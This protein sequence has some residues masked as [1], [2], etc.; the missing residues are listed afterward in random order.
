MII[1]IVNGLFLF[2]I[3]HCSPPLNYQYMFSRRTDTTG[4]KA[5]TNQVKPFFMGNP[6]TSTPFFGPVIQKKP[7]ATQAADVTADDLLK[8]AQG[9][10]KDVD[11][12]QNQIHQGT[13]ELLSTAMGG[14]TSTNDSINKDTPELL[15][16]FASFAANC[17]SL[18]RYIT[19]KPSKI[20]DKHYK[21]YAH[22][23]GNDDT[24][25]KSSGRFYNDDFHQAASDYLH[26]RD[27]EAIR[28]VGGF[29]KRQNDTINLPSDSSFGNALHE[30]VHR[31]SGPLF[32]T[33]FGQ[34]LNEGLTQRFTNKL[35]HEAHF[36]RETKSDYGDNLADMQLLLAKLQ[37]KEDLLARVYFMNDADAVKQIY[38]ALHL[39]PAG[40]N[41]PH[42]EDPD[43]ILKAIRIP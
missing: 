42:P 15:D 18:S 34:Y 33:Y 30:S 29:Y 24:S 12:M 39:L 20:K 3:S 6:V 37:G 31:L 1:F 7:A 2:V 36:T 41:L 26:T 19:L 9:T 10:V 23:R 32:Q 4:E 8:E 17:S 35:L 28:K 40:S 5:N 16:I 22:Y 25:S 21:T 27:R 11:D 43:N 14:I 13:C 38:T